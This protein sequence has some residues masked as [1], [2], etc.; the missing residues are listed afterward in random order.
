MTTPNSISTSF[1]F[2]LKAFA[3]GFIAVIVAHQG[4]IAALNAGGLIPPGMTPW[5]FDPVPPFGVPSLISKAFWGG[6]WGIV[7]AAVLAGRRGAAYWF[8][9][10]VLGAV[11]LSLVAL[12]VVPALKGLPPPDFMARFP[13]A[14]LINGTWG[15]GTA[16]LLSLM[17]GGS[18]Q[19]RTA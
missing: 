6:A 1:G 8:G 10:T 14:A 16:V 19:S 4:L 18:G 2:A 3:A 5:S 11:A 13:I 15:L 17:R 12:L 9:W 7:I